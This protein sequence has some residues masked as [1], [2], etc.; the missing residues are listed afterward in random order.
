MRESIDAAAIAARYARVVARIAAAARRSGR[1]PSTITLVAVTKAFSSEAA[2]AALAAGATHL[3]ENYVQEALPKIRAVDEVCQR[4]DLP[5]P[6][7]HLIGHL[8]HNKAR[9]AVETFDII[10]S[11]DS[12][13]LARRLDRIGA[14]RGTRVRVL[15]EVNTSGEATKNGIPTAGAPALVATLTAL[16]HLQLEGLMTVP[17]RSA[18]ADGAR[19]HFR[20]LAALR[21]ELGTRGFDLPHLSMGMTDDYETAIEE[22]ATIVRIGRAIFGE[23]PGRRRP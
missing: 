8:Q 17:P 1:D 14:D 20:A 22:G 11:L 15:L 10:H 6:Q 18:A 4:R 16:D 12:E 19:G 21:D 2:C 5:T 3:G 13:A 9:R 23:R 7:W